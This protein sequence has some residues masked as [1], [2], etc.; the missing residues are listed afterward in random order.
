MIIAG[1]VVGG[2]VLLEGGSS[3]PEGT[4]VTVSY[5]GPLASKSNRE[6]KRFQVPLVR[7]FVVETGAEEAEP[8]LDFHWSKKRRKLR[9]AAKAYSEQTHAD[10]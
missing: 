5:D 3:L 1:K 10:Y 8:T 7:T 6:K 9:A 4:A 2:V